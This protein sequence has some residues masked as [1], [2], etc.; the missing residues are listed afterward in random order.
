MNI[1]QLVTSPTTTQ[2]FASRVIDQSKDSTLATVGGCHKRMS[3]LTGK[4]PNCKK[5]LFAA[6]DLALIKKRPK[7][8]VIS[9]SFINSSFTIYSLNYLEY[10]FVCKIYLQV[11]LE[12]LFIEYPSLF[13]YLI[14]SDYRTRKTHMLAQ[15]LRA[16]VGRRSIESNLK[17][18]LQEQQHRLDEYFETKELRFTKL[19]KE[20]KQKINYKD[21]AVLCK[22]VN[23][24]KT[25]A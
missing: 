10:N 9:I 6:D 17:D 25:L 15:D 22:D 24:L 16:V 13:L 12:N 5:P 11:T 2:A 20:T 7:P 3:I 8:E 1:E 18:V 19:D 21:Y 14:P 23:G 4:Q